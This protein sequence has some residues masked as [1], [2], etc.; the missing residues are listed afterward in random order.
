[1][2]WIACS[3]TKAAPMPLDVLLRQIDQAA[4][5]G[6]LRPLDAAFARFLAE[7]EG[8]GSPLAPML[9]ALVSQQSGEGHLCL[10]LGALEDLADQLDLPESWRHILSN[11]PALAEQLDAS[12]VIAHDEQMSASPLVLDHGRLY[13]RRY[14]DHERLVAS[15]IRQRLLT[16]ITPPAGLRQELLRLF[17][18]DNSGTIQWPRVACALAARSAFTVITG[19]P[20]TGKT[21]AVVRLLG[22]LQ[23]LQ[24]AEHNRPLRIRLAAPTGKAAARLNASIASQ[25]AALDVSEAVR[26]AIPTDVVTLHRLLGARPESRRFH[27]QANN[28]LHL[29]V[30]VID[31]ASMIDLELMSSVLAALPPQARLIL[32]GDKD[33]LSSVEA[34]AVLGDL[35]KRAQEGHYSP[36]TMQWLLE[37]SGDDIGDWT[38]EDAHLLDQHVAMLRSSHR[39]DS[40]SGIGRLAQAVNAGDGLVS[41]TLL[42]SAQADLHWQTSPLDRASLR[43]LVLDTSRGY[44]YY[45]QALNAHRPPHS[46]DQQKYEAWAHRVL[47]AFECFRLLCALRRGDHGTSGVNAQVASILHQAG[48]I[49]SESGWYEGKPVLMTRND[50]TLGL[51]NGD[52][53]V[54]LEVPALDGGTHLRVAFKS[55]IDGPNGDSRVRLVQPS[56]LG[57][58]EPAYA[59]TVH[60]S[61]GSEFD[62]VAL[63]LPSE[64]TTVVSREL[65]YTAVTRTRS[66]FHLIGSAEIIDSAVL[67]PTRRHSALTK[68]LLD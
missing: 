64:N 5:Q 15:T 54:T 3:R 8:T 42:S 46:S 49:S 48:K 10:E 40:A 66:S 9:G 45:L 19:G 60:K 34:G 21:T 65:L 29:D 59:M 30:L 20:G 13:L 63:I 18:D 36:A 62:H 39:F 47:E 55:D 43:S 2:P 1:M 26:A 23:T 27:Y 41:R 14:W 16:P 68:R 12:T 22:L 56:R 6:R 24:L 28:R 57:S 61:Q 11:A 44:G 51:M 25:V 31:E 52:I 17:P 50:Y 38:S 53:G 33:Q 58:Y 35:C 4:E 67:R 37:T 32:L 7:Q